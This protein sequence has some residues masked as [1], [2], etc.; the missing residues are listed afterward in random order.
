MSAATFFFNRQYV[1]QI[2]VEG[3]WGCMRSTTGRD[4]GSLRSHRA[5]QGASE[6]TWDRIG[7]SEVTWDRIGASEVTWG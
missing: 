7:A 4:K 2:L 6:V 1:P 3:T 5:E